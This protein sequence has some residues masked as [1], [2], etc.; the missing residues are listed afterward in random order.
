MPRTFRLFL[1]SLA[2]VVFVLLWMDSGLFGQ[3]RPKDEEWWTY[4]GDLASR[5]YKP[6]DQINRENFKDLEVA[7]RQR[8]GDL[9]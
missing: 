9:A 2:S 3:A 6:F 4:G 5:R 1:P 8:Y 7:W